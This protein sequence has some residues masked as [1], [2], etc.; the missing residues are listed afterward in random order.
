MSVIS[1]GLQ[2]VLVVPYMLAVLSVL[3]LDCAH[4]AIHLLI[5]FFSL[6]IVE[7]S[8]DPLELEEGHIVQ[9]LSEEFPSSNVYEQY[10]NIL[11]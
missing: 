10:V 8:T 4:A 11:S 1:T 3:F 7:L 6:D 9:V 5:L 2:S